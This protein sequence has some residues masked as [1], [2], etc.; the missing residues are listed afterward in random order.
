MFVS[1]ALLFEGSLSF[2]VWLSVPIYLVGFGHVYL[3]GLGQVKP[4]WTFTTME[5]D[6]LELDMSLSNKGLWTFVIM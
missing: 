1:L 6:A 4:F 2:V 3:A 5:P